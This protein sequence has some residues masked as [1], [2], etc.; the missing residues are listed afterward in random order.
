MSATSH[1]DVQVL[2]A[3]PVRLEIS[4]AA[5]GRASSLVVDGRELLVTEGD[6]PMQWGS[7][8]MAPW[9][10]RTRRGAFRF[11]GRDHRL[12]VNLPPH[13]IHGT[14]FDRPWA[15]EGP[16]VVSIDLGPDWPFRGRVTQRYELGPAS[17][18][19]VMTLEADDPMPAVLGWHPWFR[20]RLAGPDSGSGAPSTPVRLSFDAAGMYAKD[21]EGIPT[22]EIVRPPD[23][24]WD[25]CFIGLRSGPVLEW[26]GILR[27]QLDSDADHWV[28]YTEPEHAVCVEPQTGPPD[29]LNLAPRTLEP[30]QRIETSMTWRWSRPAG[31]G[32]EDALER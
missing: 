13:A 25:D 4:P 6:G 28:I 23:G 7:Y 29:G 15:V 3:G 11:G 10:G 22:G 21:A 12:P 32:D 8:P 16:G 5:G 18:R 14:V 2:T 27:L 9:A 1:E 24:P 19:V 17:L 26:P 31:S 20:R 30:G